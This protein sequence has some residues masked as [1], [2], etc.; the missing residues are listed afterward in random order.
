MSAKKQLTK[1]YKSV[2]SVF[3]CCAV[4]LQINVLNSLKTSAYVLQGC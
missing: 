4:S 1:S 2:H 3:A